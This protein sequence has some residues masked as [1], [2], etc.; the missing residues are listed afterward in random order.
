MKRVLL[1]LT[2]V[3]IG[4]VSFAQEG[5]KKVED[6]IKFKELKYN[7]G[8]IKQGVPVTHDFVFSN[9]GDGPAVIENA[10]ASCGCTTPTWP[11]QP[12]M[13]GKS[14][15]VTAGFNAAAPGTFEKSIYVK[16][17]GIDYPLEI[18]ISGE[19]LNADEYAKYESTKKPK[20][21]SK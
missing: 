2:L 7:F 4:M 3:G 21:G 1:A 11:Q 16:L 13:K 20:T 8:K 6:F 18:K 9:V 12:I 19:V 15:K 10:S 14:D 5:V 17:K